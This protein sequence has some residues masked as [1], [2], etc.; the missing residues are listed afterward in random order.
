MLNSLMTLLR[1]PG[2][3]F[4]SRTE[5]GLREPAAVI[6]SIVVLGLG[7]G[8]VRRFLVSPLVTRNMG[9]FGGTDM[10]AS[11]QMTATLV[12]SGLG[13]AVAAVG[14]IIGPFLWWA[15]FAGIFYLVTE[16][17]DGTGD[18]QDV[19]A[20]TGLGLIPR[21]VNILVAIVLGLV[22]AGLIYFGITPSVA[23]WLNALAALIGVGTT[24]WS[25]YI[26]AHGVAE[27]RNVTQKQGYIAVAPV[28]VLGVISALLGVLFRVLGGFLTG[29]A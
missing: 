10:A 19:L 23:S 7:L 3:Y 20:V 25:G 27:V 8:L 21:A 16:V 28:V 15:L 18:F 1:D 13:F 9:R 24:L 22:A 2:A 17:F 6:V 4:E 26:W 29:M 14:K 11:E 12:G 5:F